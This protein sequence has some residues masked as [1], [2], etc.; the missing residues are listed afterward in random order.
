MATAMAKARIPGLMAHK[1]VGECKDGYSHGQGTMTF[2]SGDKYVGEFKD[3]NMHGQGTYTF[4]DGDKI[5]WGM[6]RW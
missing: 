2:A 6:E 5:R 1:Y 4:A 3:D